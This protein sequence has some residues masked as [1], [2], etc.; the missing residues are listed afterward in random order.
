M[1]WRAL[2]RRAFPYL[3][4]AVGGFLIAYVAVFLFAFPAEVLPDDGILP[5]VVGKTTGAAEATLGAAS[6]PANVQQQTVTNQTQKGVVLSQSPGASSQVKKGTGVTAK[7]PVNGKAPVKGKG[8][9]QR[10]DEE[11]EDDEAP[12]KKKQGPSTTLVLGIGLAAL[13][14]V[15]LGV[16]GFFL[17]SGSDAKPTKSAS[18][19]GNN[20]PAPKEEEGPKEAPP[21][22]VLASVGEVTH[23]LPNDTER[24]F[25]VNVER[26]MRA[27]ALGQTLF[28]T[29]GGFTPALIQ[30]KL[31]IPVGDI[32]RLL[33]A[34]SQSQKWSFNVLRTSKKIDMDTVKQLVGADDKNKKT[35]DDFCHLFHGPPSTPPMVKPYTFD[36][37]VNTLN[38][39]VPYDW[40]GFWT[41]RLTN[42]GPGAP[43]G[44]IEGSGWKLVY[45][46]T[47]SEMERGGENTFHFVDAAYSVG[48]HL[49]EDG[50]ITDTV[51]GMPAALAGIGPGMKL[52]AVN[53]RKFSPEVLHDSL[54]A[55]KGGAAPLELLIENT[56]YYKT[57]KL[58]YHGGA[59]YPHL[60]RD[61]TK[62]DLLA[63]IYKAK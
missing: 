62:A 35:I 28:N 50:T 39:V 26:A 36:D 44:G 9:Q 60:V 40:R 43:L 6:F 12:V 29:P 30:A 46:E 10:P 54:N 47:Q 55:S 42:H 2:P 38:Q 1:N 19:A 49:R 48:M 25:S 56:D 23:L 17:F 14:V 22:P 21:A 4:A 18:S 13:A 37:V 57:Y 3:I 41:E 59:R 24:V 8:L 31:G 32:S 58:N 33:N 34:Q 45:D 53:G 5:N 11:D 61:E 20:N 27:S 7:K 63:E 16:G 51:E 15:L 52:I